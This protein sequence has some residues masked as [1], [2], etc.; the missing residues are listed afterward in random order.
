MAPSAASTPPQA[1]KAAG[2][3]GRF[4]IGIIKFVGVIVLFAM[5]TLSMLQRNHYFDSHH[6]NANHPSGNN[7]HAAITN[8]ITAKAS[9]VDHA[10]HNTVQI[11]TKDNGGKFFVAKSVFKD[12]AGASASASSP[13]L[14]PHRPARRSLWE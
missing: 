7:S 3:R 6:S 1:A 4:H 9:D 2:S 10:L 14:P 13:P 5:A 12:V 11:M 8:F